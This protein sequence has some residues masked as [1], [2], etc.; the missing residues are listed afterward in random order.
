[1]TTDTS[2]GRDAQAAAALGQAAVEVFAE[3][4]FGDVARAHTVFMA[5]FR[6]R[7]A[8]DECGFECGQLR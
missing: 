1:M 2:A 4:L 5:R 8:G 7:G 6:A 3:K